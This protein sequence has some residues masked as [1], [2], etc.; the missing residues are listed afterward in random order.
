MG[1]L[2]VGVDPG[3]R[4]IGI[5]ARRGVDVL[6]WH[7]IDTHDLEPDATRPGRPTLED[8][9][10]TIGEI[11]AG[12]PFRVA[13]EDVDPPNAHHN[14]QVSIIQVE[15]LLRTAE[16]IGYVERAYPDAVRVPPRGN[17]SRTLASYP[18]CLV[19]NREYAN[20][21]RKGALLA[22]APQNSSLRHARSAYDVAGAAATAVRIAKS[23]LQRE[24]HRRTHAATPTARRRRTF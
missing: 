4:W 3:A 1:T 7:V 23:S 13:V 19:G 6:G 11:V 22:D 21:V 2:W 24:L 15:P 10:N 14:G 17:G 8:I 16:V 20:A 18:R 5:C 12:Q 9:V